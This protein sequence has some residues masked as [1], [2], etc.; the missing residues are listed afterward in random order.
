MR[1]VSNCLNAILVLLTLPIYVLSLIAALAGTVI[2]AF[3][4][5]WRPTGCSSSPTGR[6]C[7]SRLGCLSG[8]SL[9]A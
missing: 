7:S 3:A 6:F 1:E 2:G 4:P 8:I 5:T 9:L